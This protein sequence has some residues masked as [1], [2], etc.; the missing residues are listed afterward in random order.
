MSL[1]RQQMN[2][3]TNVITHVNDLINTQ[4]NSAKQYLK[5]YYA[6]PILTH[7]DDKVQLIVVPM[8]QE[9]Y[10]NEEYCR[11]FEDI[12]RAV[13]NQFNLQPINLE[14]MRS[15]SYH[16]CKC[17]SKYWSINVAHHIN[18]WITPLTNHRN[19]ILPI[20]KYYH[21]WDIEEKEINYKYYTE[22]KQ[23]LNELFEQVDIGYKTA[24]C[25]LNEV[26]RTP[27]PSPQIPITYNSETDYDST[28]SESLNE[29]TSDP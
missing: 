22:H 25:Y 18:F 17:G 16:I 15:N 4:I 5:E 20:K 7:M 9:I 26:I 2:T 21:L 8:L 13:F 6:I 10:D 12:I 1:N 19:I 11:N 29:N 28:S 24:C 23:E 27:P 3:S 14:W